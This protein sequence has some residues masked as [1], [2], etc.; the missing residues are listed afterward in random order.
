[1]NRKIT[2][3]IKL[4]ILVLVTTLSSITYFSAPRSL[5][6]E[7]SAKQG[8]T[9]KQYELGV[10]YLNSKHTSHYRCPNA[11]FICE[12]IDNVINN[13]EIQSSYDRG[14][15][16]LRESLNSGNLNAKFKLS[17]ALQEGNPGLS[18]SPTKESIKESKAL[19]EQLV[20]KGY[21]GAYYQLGWYYLKGIGGTVDLNR[22]IE[23]LN[24]AKEK[25]YPNAHSLLQTVKSLHNTNKEINL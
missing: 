13:I 16:W 10:Y 6:N 4:I 20:E 22:A 25:N 24:V 8:N 9:L 18:S 23:Y 2:L 5:I 11:S 12:Y 3:A 17:M 14:I 1:M 19:L 15:Y 21:A 7:D